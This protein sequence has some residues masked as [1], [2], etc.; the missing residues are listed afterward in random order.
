MLPSLKSELHK[1]SYYIRF[2]LRVK[3]AKNQRIKTKVTKSHRNEGLD[4]KIEVNSNLI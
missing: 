2:V 3:V 4:V 1:C